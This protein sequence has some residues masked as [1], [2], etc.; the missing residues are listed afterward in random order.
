MALQLLLHGRPHE[1]ALAEGGGSR[2]RPASDARG[3]QRRQ[4]VRTQQRRHPCSQQTFEKT[5]APDGA[6]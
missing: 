1:P 6:P 5:K 2:G 4:P 3:V